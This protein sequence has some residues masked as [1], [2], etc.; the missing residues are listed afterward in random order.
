MVYEEDGKGYKLRLAVLHI[1]PETV[2]FLV[3]FSVRPSHEVITM[4]LCKQFCLR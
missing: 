3:V 1:A 4:L 2:I